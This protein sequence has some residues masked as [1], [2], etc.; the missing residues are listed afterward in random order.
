L[1]K[2]ERKYNLV[3][4][5]LKP[6]SFSYSHTQISDRL[7]S[8]LIFPTLKRKVRRLY[9]PSKDYLK[10][11]SDSAQHWHDR[12]KHVGSR[13]LERLVHQARNVKIISIPRIKCEIYTIIYIKQVVSRRPSEHSSLRPF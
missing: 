1:K 6:L 8:I 7:A 13:S 5:E 10:P 2:L 9:R 4:I 11:R 3:F 12:V